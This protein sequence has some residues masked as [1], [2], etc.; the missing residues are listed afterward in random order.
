MNKRTFLSAYTLLMVVLS[1]SVAFALDPMGPPT[2]GLKKGHSIVGGEYF[3]EEGEIRLDNGE[4]F[5]SSVEP[6][7]MTTRVHMVTAI[8]GYG[9]MDNWE[10]FLRIGSGIS[11][12]ANGNFNDTIFAGSYSGKLEF[13]G[14][15]GFVIG[16]GSKVTLYEQQ[17][18]KVGVLCQA[19]VSRH[20]G[21]MK[22]F[23]TDPN[24]GFVIPWD[25]EVYI[26]EVQCAVGPTYQ[27][28][29]KVTIYGGPF[30]SYIYGE[31][32]GDYKP[33]A[34][35]PTYKF[36]YDVDNEFSFGGY[37][38]ALIDLGGNLSCTAEYL[39]SSNHDAFGTSL[40]WTY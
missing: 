24:S 4:V 20:E 6:I 38:G 32:D 31:V 14:D 19:S 21:N 36:S 18:L 11:G 17:K 9:V 7:D 29:D 15:G 22:H 16:A 8:V 13:D 27:W 23:N 28:T 35:S 30:L 34:Y 2:A 25:T 33:S 39:H 12:R 5:G 37:I 40:L 10:A 1:G 26:Y 3:F